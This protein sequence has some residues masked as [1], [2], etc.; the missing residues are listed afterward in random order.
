LGPAIETEVA[1]SIERGQMGS[2][3]AL[4][5]DYGKAVLDSIGNECKKMYEHGVQPILLTSPNVRPAMRKL[6][7]RSYPN[8]VV[9]SWNEIAPRVTVKPLGMVTLREV[10]STDELQIGGR[11]EANPG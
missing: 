11:N 8:L 3:L 9:L 4:D 6:T 5:P 7:D 2:F 10:H 1:N